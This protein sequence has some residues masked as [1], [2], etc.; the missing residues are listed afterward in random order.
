M[1]EGKSMDEVAELVK[2]PPHLKKLSYLG[3]YYGKIEWAVRAIYTA[4][5]GWFDGNPTNLSRLSQKTYAKK[6]INLIGDVEQLITAWEKAMENE[7][8][9]WALELSDLI[10]AVSEEEGKQ[11]K[12]Q[13]LKLIA[14]E[15][16]SAN[17]R[18]FYL[19]YAKKLLL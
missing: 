4:Y 8:Y 15:E 3:E 18:H 7:E 12:V 11:L 17:G 6:I 2:L 19:D 10:I 16:T 14:L 5:L 9:Q 13:T 1:N